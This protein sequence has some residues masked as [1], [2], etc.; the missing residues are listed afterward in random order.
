MSGNSW[1]WRETEKCLGHIGNS[2]LRHIK[3][4]PYHITFYKE[5]KTNKYQV[6]TVT[7]SGFISFHTSSTRAHNVPAVQCKGGCIRKLIK[8]GIVKIIMKGNYYTT[9]PD[10]ASFSFFYYITLHYLY[11]MQLNLTWVTNNGA[12]REHE[13]ITKVR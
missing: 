1:V 3:L 12:L 4:L 8:N 10:S 13:W 11:L 7:R 2:S 6:Q 9:H 5:Y